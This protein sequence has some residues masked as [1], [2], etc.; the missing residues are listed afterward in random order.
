M[1]KRRSNRRSR[2][3][4][5][6]FEGRSYPVLDRLRIGTRNY[7]LLEKI[8]NAQRERYLAIDPA[9]GPGGEFRSVLI[10]PRSAAAIQHLAV[11]RPI[12]F[13]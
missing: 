11:L 8:G 12:P 9:A 3:D 2:D 6:N 13:N 10:L 7:L 1:A 4:T 5:F